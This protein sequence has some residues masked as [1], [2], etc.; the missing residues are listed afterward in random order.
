MRQ[1]VLKRSRFGSIAAHG[2]LQKKNTKRTLWKELKGRFFTSLSEQPAFFSYSSKISLFFRFGFKRCTWKPHT[3]TDLASLKSR[4]SWKQ[5]RKKKCILKQNN[6]MKTLNNPTSL[7]NAIHESW[8]LRVYT[9]F[10]HIF[11]FF[12]IL[13]CFSIL[14][15]WTS[16]VK[17]RA[18]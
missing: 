17:F 2:K 15:V 18:G 5:L 1:R 13:N 10:S 9:I 16:H 8:I 6:V 3:L 4:H 14:C 7:W 11:F 12:I